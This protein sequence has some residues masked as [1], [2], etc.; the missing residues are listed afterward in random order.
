[1]VK[2]PQGSDP[3]STKNV[4]VNHVFEDF[5]VFPHSKMASKF[6]RDDFSDKA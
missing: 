2:N 4:S 6:K 5:Y 3:F 1:M